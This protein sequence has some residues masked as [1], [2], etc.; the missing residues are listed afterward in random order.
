MFENASVSLKSMILTGCLP[1]VPMSNKRIPGWNSKIGRLARKL[2][3]GAGSTLL[4]EADAL[5]T[6]IWNQ[7]LL[8]DHAFKSGLARLIVI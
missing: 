1:C 3:S 2:L 5:I 8:R 7:R 6:S 4:Y